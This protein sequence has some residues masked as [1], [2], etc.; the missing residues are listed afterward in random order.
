MSE[1]EPQSEKKPPETAAA[2]A[3]PGPAAQDPLAQARAKAEE[4]R[5]A[6]LRALADADNARKRAQAEIA[7]ARKFAAERV[8]EDLFPVMDSLEAALAQDTAEPAAVRAGVELTRRQLQSA[9]EKAGVSAINADP[10]Q[11]FDPYR[12]QAMAAVESD[13]EP[14]TVLAVLQKGYALHDRVVRP[15]LVTVAKSRAVEN[16]PGNPISDNNLESN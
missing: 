2:E 5:E 8:V 10:G 15:A 14:N 9:L 12:H 13:Q 11:K 3:Q 6:W 1:A 16:G 4:H 7:Q